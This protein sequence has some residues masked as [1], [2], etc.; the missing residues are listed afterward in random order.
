LL[1]MSS[2]YSIPGINLGLEL[3]PLFL[4]HCFNWGLYGLLALQVFLY[5][6]SFVNDPRSHKILVYTVFFID[7]VS[8]ACSTYSGYWVFVQNWGNVVVFHGL[9]W[10]WATVP[11]STGL[12]A[13]IVQTFYAY[14]V[15]R[16]SQ[17]KNWYIPVFIVVLAG[18][19]CGF[20]FAA[21]NEV[22][23]LQTFTYI[24]L[25]IPSIWLS[26]GIAAD[27]LVC[28]ALVY[29]FTISTKVR[30][31]LTNRLMMRLVRIVVETAIITIIAAALKMYLIFSRRDN[32][33]LLF[34]L[35]LPRLYSNA[36]MGSLNSRSS[37]FGGDQVRTTDRRKDLR[38][39]TNPGSSFN[40]FL[41]K[42]KLNR[43]SSSYAQ[44]DMELGLRTA[45]SHSQVLH[46]QPTD[47]ASLISPP[48]ATH[49]TPAYTP[50]SP[51]PLITFTPSTEITLRNQ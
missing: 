37:V 33:H 7:T 19:S 18:I 20:S 32:M 42:K 8:I 22:A 5:Y 45:D 49:S 13:L 46:Y 6:G 34:C 40:S 15:Y 36:L 17:N 39:G 51:P 12:V 43:E 10:S 25:L 38:I 14:R 27:F 35:L 24:R 1:S 11:A 21:A 47:N 41:E 23:H 3:G 9:G 28:A 48:P 4:A 16:V 30:F 44:T 2:N 26:F 29:Y 50:R 31:T